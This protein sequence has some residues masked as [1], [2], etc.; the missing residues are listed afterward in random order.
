MAKVTVV[1]KRVLDEGKPLISP[2]EPSSFSPVLIDFVVRTTASILTF[3]R[4]RKVRN[5]TC[6][7]LILY[8]QTSWQ[9]EI[10]KQPPTR[11]LGGSFQ[12]PHKVSLSKLQTHGYMN[13][14]LISS[15]SSSS[16]LTQRAAGNE[17]GRKTDQVV[18][19][20]Q[21]NICFNLFVSGF[22][23]GLLNQIS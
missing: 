15:P 14:F 22:Q 18:W 13:V 8:N 12:S 2:D 19:S 17:R 10:H 9:I 20:Q 11:Y 1:E 3:L 4:W 21:W 6:N 7:T 23:V 5:C 16:S